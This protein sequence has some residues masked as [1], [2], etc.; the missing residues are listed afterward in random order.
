MKIY[1]WISTILFYTILLFIVIN[2][3]V[4]IWTETTLDIILITISFILYI[5]MLSIFVFK[6]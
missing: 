4:S 3:I 2:I 5:I 1:S 6:N